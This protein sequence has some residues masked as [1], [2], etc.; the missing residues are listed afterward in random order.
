MTKRIYPMDAGPEMDRLIAEHI[1]VNRQGADG[2]ITTIGVITAGA[3][4]PSTNI[5]HAREVLERM[6]EN[7]WNV[8]DIWDIMDQTKTPL[9]ICRAA[10]M[11]METHN[12]QA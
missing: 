8:D 6:V 12:D 10:L 11:A 3:W 9:A 1:M 7:G 2:A 5:T 4:S